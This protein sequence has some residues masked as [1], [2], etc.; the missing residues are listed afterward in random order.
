VLPARA[1]LIEFRQYRRANF[2]TGEM[3][4]P[5]FAGL[6]LAGSDEP[7]VIDVGSVAELQSLEAALDDEAAATL[8]RKVFEPFG[9]KLATVTTVYVAPDGILDLVPFA[10]LKLADGRYWGERQEVRLL[11]SGRDLLRPDSDKAARGL[12]VLGGS[13][14]VLRESNPG[15]QTALFLIEVV[16][17]PSPERRALSAAVSPRCRRAARKPRR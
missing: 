8:F 12:L 5:R 13:T 16:R 7:V 14:T 10:R 4:E 6:L 1:V 3:G 17:T 15:S 2:Q 9:Q 11:Q